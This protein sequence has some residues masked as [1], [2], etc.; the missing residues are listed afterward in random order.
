MHKQHPQTAYRKYAVSTGTI[1]E[2]CDIHSVR[3]RHGVDG[4]VPA[5]RGVRVFYLFFFSRPPGA[6]G[7]FLGLR[8]L[9]EG[10]LPPEG[11]EMCIRDRSWREAPERLYEGGPSRKSQRGQTS[12]SRLAAVIAVAY[13][14]EALAYR[15]VFLST[16]I[17]YSGA[18]R[19]PYS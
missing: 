7:L 8:Q 3:R 14:G 16:I 15:K 4:P 17:G 1:F 10:D 13:R 9:F 19:N 11:G 6:E 18:S 12:P 5:G 2:N